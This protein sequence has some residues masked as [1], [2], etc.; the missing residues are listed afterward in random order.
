MPARQPA[1]FSP[2]APRRRR[3]AI[4]V[5]CGLLLPILVAMV[6]LVIDGGLMLAVY[7]AGQNSADAAA[8]AAAMDMMLGR[9]SAQTTAT[10]TTYVTDRAYNAQ[11]RDLRDATVVVNIPPSQG[12]Y[13]GN[14]HYVEVVVTCPITTNF[15][16]VL[17]G[18]N[19]NQSVTARAVAGFEMVSAG[20]GV[21][22]LD[23]TAWPGLDV[24]G[25]G[26][27][28]V[29]GRV[30]VNS[31]GGG[32]DELGQPSL[33]AQQGHS[34]WGA[35]GGQPNSNYGIF[36]QDIQVVGGVDNPTSFKNVD[37]DNSDSPLHCNSLP[38]PDRF[39]YLPTPSEANG[40]TATNWGKVKVTN[41]GLQ[42]GGLPDWDDGVKVTLQPGIYEQLTVTGYTV[43]L[44]PGIYVLSG[45]NTN[46]LSLTGG[47]VTGDGVMFYNTGQNYI[48]ATG[49]PDASDPPDP[50]GT[51]PPPKTADTS[52]GD[53]TIN[54][55]MHFT[56]IDSTKYSYP[57][58]EIR[59]FDGM[60]F[61]QRRANKKGVSIEGNANAGKLDGVIYAKWAPFKISGQGTYDA[62]FIVGSISV[63]GGGTVIIRYTGADKGLAP[64]VFLVQ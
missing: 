40:V 26:A 34:R 7:R 61:Y 37:P 55:S 38:E 25:G 50:W 47:Q 19:R 20:E 24:S 11:D 9:S 8:L 53:V 51:S 42:Q 5:W 10:A 15:L 63:S 45:P 44:E 23:P 12:A 48:A 56:P 21:M 30:I 49:A 39:R 60:L 16:H 46:N 3:G 22:T 43:V 41:D 54:A 36:G 2:R 58:A 6:G 18:F 31:E 57:N 14:D 32:V 4:L 28:K 1:R 29:K 35:K 64:Q 59:V 13:A 33:M 27:I 62:Q 17:P 52:F